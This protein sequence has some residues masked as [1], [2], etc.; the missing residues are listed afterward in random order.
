MYSLYHANTN[1]KTRERMIEWFWR[2]KKT[3]PALDSMLMTP[4]TSCPILV[5]KQNKETNYKPHHT[6]TCWPPHLQ[7][8]RCSKMSPAENK[9]APFVY[10]HI[11]EASASDF[12]RRGK[13]RQ[14]GEQLWQ[15]VWLKETVS[16][17]CEIVCSEMLCLRIDDERWHRHN[18][19]ILAWELHA[20]KNAQ[21]L[22]VAND[23]N[24]QPK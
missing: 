5:V 8:A 7:Q 11:R 6:S 15:R 4:L 16:S 2:K 13:K 3:H 17:S 9:A 23:W 22:S 18:R 19:K 14:N 24:I 10:D 1:D 12:E 21:K 20:T